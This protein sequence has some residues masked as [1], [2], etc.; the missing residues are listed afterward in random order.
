MPTY[1]LRDGLRF[2]FYSNDHEPIHVHVTKGKMGSEAHAKFA[3][4]PEVRLLENYRFS[5]R[6][7]SKAK[8]AIEERKESIIDMWNKHF[9]KE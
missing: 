5:A 4:I 6:E 1:F 8:E 3:T 9:S 2:F 7:I